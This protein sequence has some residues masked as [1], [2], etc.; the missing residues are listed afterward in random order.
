MRKS[1]KLDS[2]AKIPQIIRNCSVDKSSNQSKNSKIFIKETYY[3]KDETDDDVDLPIEILPEE[4][5]YD[6]NKNIPGFESMEKE[7][8]NSQKKDNKKHPGMIDGLSQIKQ[9]RSNRKSPSRATTNSVDKKANGGDGHYLV[10][11]Y[12]HRTCTKSVENI[13]SS[14]NDTTSKPNIQYNQQFLSNDDINIRD[15]IVAK[16]V[17]KKVGC[18]KKPNKNTVEEKNKLPIGQKKPSIC[19]NSE[20]V[21]Y[22]SNILKKYGGGGNDNINNKNKVLSTRPAPVGVTNK[23]NNKF[24]VGVNS[25]ANEKITNNGKNVKSVVKDYIC[26]NSAKPTNDPKVSNKP[27]MQ[28]NPKKGDLETDKKVFDTIPINVKYKA[29]SPYL[30]PDQLDSAKINQSCIQTFQYE[31]HKISNNLLLVSPSKNTHFDKQGHILKIDSGYKKNID[32][33]NI[34]RMLADYDHRADL[35]HQET[36]R[37]RDTCRVC[38]TLKSLSREKDYFSGEEE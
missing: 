22:N 32:A 5:E 34:E 36:T 30:S 21:N 35:A 38:D 10:S 2:I 11:Q 16:S 24:G 19:I 18:E 3:S 37:S 27:I 7:Y 23:A 28:N 12:S 25:K 1:K 33:L 26:I 20:R 13:R 4:I 8:C 6:N 17:E 9:D 31:H 14:T 15:K 29:N